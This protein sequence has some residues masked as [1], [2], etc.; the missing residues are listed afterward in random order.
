MSA[1]QPPLTRDDVG[2]LREKITTQYFSYQCD[3][4]NNPYR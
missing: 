3:Y 2:K 4:F 1:L